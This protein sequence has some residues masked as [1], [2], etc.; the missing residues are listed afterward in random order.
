MSV[1]G[2]SGTG[3]PE[4]KVSIVKAEADEVLTSAPL[5]QFLQ[6]KV[7]SGQ[8][9]QLRVALLVYFMK[10]YNKEN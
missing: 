5:S 6:V 9:K 3:A 10:Y 2:G 1:L 8:T 7:F 4:H